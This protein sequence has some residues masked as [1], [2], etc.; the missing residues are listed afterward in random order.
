MLLS[1]WIQMLLEMKKKAQGILDKGQLD[2]E[3][4]TGV[5]VRAEL[6]EVEEFFPRLFGPT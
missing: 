2:S 4:A 3:V 5:C 6:A 1:Y